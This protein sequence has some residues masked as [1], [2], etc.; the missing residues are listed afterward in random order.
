MHKICHVDIK[1]TL[2]GQEK[3][4]PTSEVHGKQRIMKGTKEGPSAHWLPT[5]LLHFSLQ[6]H[7]GGGQER[8]I[9]ASEQWICGQTMACW[10]HRA[11]PAAGAEVKVTAQPPQAASDGTTTA[12]SC[13]RRKIFSRAALQKSYVF[14]LYTTPSLGEQSTELFQTLRFL[15]ASRIG[16]LVPAT[17]VGGI[18]KAPKS[19]PNRR[20]KQNYFTSDLTSESAVR[21]YFPCWS[22]KT[23]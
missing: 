1:N 20:N 5:R 4:C 23:N 8:K 19:W 3:I 12:A 18:F 13:E 14:L 9:T 10:H 16:V 17:K 22:Q 15:F 6:R 2:C 11:A 7:S 21:F